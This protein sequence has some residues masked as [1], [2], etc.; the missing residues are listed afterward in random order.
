VTGVLF[1]LSVAVDSF[2]VTRNTVGWLLG[3]PRHAA[4][5][6]HAKASVDQQGVGGFAFAFYHILNFVWLYVLSGIILWLR[7]RR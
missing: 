3:W 6:V 7:G 1:A 4:E 5:A 2:E